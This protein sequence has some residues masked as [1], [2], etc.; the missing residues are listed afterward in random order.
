MS[1]RQA[2]PER[3]F[4][5][6]V[7]VYPVYRQSLLSSFDDCALATLF[8]LEG[9]HFTNSAQARGIIFHRFAAE[10]LR[11]LRRTGETRMPTEEAMAILYEQSAQRDVPDEDVVIVPARERRLLRIASLMFV[12]NEFDM[13]KLIDVERRLEATVVYDSG[14]GP[15]ERLVS[16]QP[17][18]L[19]ADPPTEEDPDSGAVVLDWK[20]T[21]KAPPKGDAGDHWDDPARLSYEGYFQQRVYAYL[22]LKTYPSVNRVRLREYYVLDR[23]ARYGTVYRGDMEHLERELSV[24]VELLDRAIMGGSKSKL[25]QPSPGR[26]CGYCPAAT[27]CPILPDERVAQGGITSQAQAEKVG[28]QFVVVDEAR[29]YLR[30]GAKNWVEVHGPLSVKSAKGRYELRFRRNKTGKGKTF[31]MYVPDDSDR[32]PKDP[33]LEAIFAEVAQRAKSTGGEI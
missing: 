13:H 30:Q 27:R 5:T 6:L 2:L 15:L 31:G 33:N 26:H 16:G 25:W 4:E 22:V 32:G 20:T 14:E 17:D 19:L 7:S 12:S 1:R 11:T 23:V 10:V 18:A 3:S 21:L 9:Y 8:D 28:A 29:E 24:Q